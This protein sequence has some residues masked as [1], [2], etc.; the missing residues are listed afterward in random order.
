VEGKTGKRDSGH[1]L[2]ELPE[3][4]ARLNDHGVG[5]IHRHV[6]DGECA[7]RCG[8]SEAD[9]AGRTGRGEALDAGRKRRHR[10]SSDI[11]QH[12][13]QGQG[14]GGGSWIVDRAAD[15]SGLRNPCAP[16]RAAGTAGRSGHLKPNE[17]LRKEL[18][19]SK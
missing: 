18:E 10:A 7:V 16:S 8:V 12:I 19:R 14:T 15:D 2:G 5:G 9:Y 11:D 13:G 4:F 1:G 3:P 6:A 17:R